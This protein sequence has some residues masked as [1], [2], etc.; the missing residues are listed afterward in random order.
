MKKQMR[1][2][3]S[4]GR[5]TSATPAICAHCKDRHTSGNRGHRVFTWGKDYVEG[6]DD[7]LYTDIE[8]DAVDKQVSDRM[9][10]EIGN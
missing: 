4:C 3:I 5:D 7:Y 6:V 10:E 1:C 9:N 8:I 2:C